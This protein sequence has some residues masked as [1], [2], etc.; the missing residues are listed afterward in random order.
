M[1]PHLTLTLSLPIGWE[2]RGNSGWTRFVPRRSGEQRPVHGPNT[3]Q[4]FGV[5]AYHWRCAW[6]LTQ[7]VSQFRKEDSVGGTPTDAVE[8]TALPE[9]VSNDSSV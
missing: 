8:T 3:R 7:E 2:R 9:K 5:E 4:D 1:N 6:E